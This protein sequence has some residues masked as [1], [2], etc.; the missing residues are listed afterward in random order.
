MFKVKLL[1][2]K[3]KQIY[4]TSFY[5]KLFWIQKRARTHNNMP[6]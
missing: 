6:M 1:G 5:L 3:V 4:I 2:S